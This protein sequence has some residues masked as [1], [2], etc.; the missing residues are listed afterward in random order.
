[1]SDGI[2]SVCKTQFR[3]TNEVISINLACAQLSPSILLLEHLIHE[4]PENKEPSKW[5][6]HMCVCELVAFSFTYFTKANILSQSWLLKFCVL[7]LYL[8][9]KFLFSVMLVT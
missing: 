7:L 5:R 9:A 4:Y 1:M 3:D 6:Y 8:S 2:H